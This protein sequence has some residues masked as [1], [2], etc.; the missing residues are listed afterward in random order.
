MDNASSLVVKSTL[1]DTTVDGN[2]ELPG[3][4]TIGFDGKKKMVIVVVRYP[5]WT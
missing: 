4:L 3:P 1:H 2:N 5:R